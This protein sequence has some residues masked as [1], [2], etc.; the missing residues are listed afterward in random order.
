MLKTVSAWQVPSTQGRALD[1]DRTCIFCLKSNPFQ[2][3]QK[4]IR[5]GCI[6]VYQPDLLLSLCT[7]FLVKTPALANVKS[8]M[9]EGRQSSL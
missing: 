3:V 2:K 4:L 7:N 6:E 5:P 1:T 8:R 9:L